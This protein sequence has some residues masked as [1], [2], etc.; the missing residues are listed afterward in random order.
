MKRIRWVVWVSMALAGIGTASA[1]ELD[2]AE[3]AAEMTLQVQV[4]PA[5]N[6]SAPAKPNSD[7]EAE[8]KALEAQKE[9][10]R[11]Y[12]RMG[13]K[14]KTQRGQIVFCKK[15]AQLGSRFE[16]EI[17]MTESQMQEFF[18]NSN[19]Q[20]ESLRSVHQSCNGKNCDIH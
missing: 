10:W 11:Q 1:V 9:Q 15:E 19:L 8:K 18:Y 5:A 14:Q 12:A 17:C 6:P 16:N 3:D 20:R 13:Y 7:P 2:V 4:S